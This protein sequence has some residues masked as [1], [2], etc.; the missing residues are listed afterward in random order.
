MNITVMT[1]IAQTLLTF[2]NLCIMVYAFSKFLSK[3]HDSLEERVDLLEI[4]I[5]EHDEILNANVDK[6]KEQKK[7]DSLIINSLVALIEFEVDYCMHHGDEK[8]SPR[9]DKAKNDLQ[10]YLAEK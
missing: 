1:S 6:Y 9:L 5:K 10:N 4:K 7:T 2:G 8:I 3:P